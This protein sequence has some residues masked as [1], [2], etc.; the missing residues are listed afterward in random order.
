MRLA[1]LLSAWTKR[2][3][4]E[5]RLLSA[6]LGCFLRADVL[7]PDMLVGSLADSGRPVI[8]QTA[9]SAE[10]ADQFSEVWG[11]LG[12]ELRPSIH[13]AVIA[14]FD[15]SRSMPVGPPVTETPRITVVRPD[16]VTEAP[17]RGRGAAHG[18][19]RGRPAESNPE[20]VPVPALPD[21]V[22]RAGVEDEPDAS[23][24]CGRCPNGDERHFPMSGGPDV[25][26]ATLTRLAALERRVRDAVADG[27]LADPATIDALRGL[28]VSDQQAMRIAHDGP[29]GPLAGGSLGSLVGSPLEPLAER[30]DLDEID[31]DLLL[32]AA[33]PDLDPRAT[34]SCSAIST[35]TSPSGGPR[36]G[37][38]CVSHVSR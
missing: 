30:L 2:A 18:A 35:T 1:Y 6:L 11:A 26:I 24:A 10:S 34:S 5:H 7:P 19:R 37:S 3:E 29:P 36:S 14:P 17:R 16:E 15:V 4:D 25:R 22:V 28:V 12:G 13:L 20:E 38:H 32:I 33:A 8:T 23:S 31:L 21:E 27:Q 9:I